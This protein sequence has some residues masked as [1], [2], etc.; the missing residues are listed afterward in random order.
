MSALQRQVAELWMGLT[1]QRNCGPGTLS[2]CV[3]D[4]G[5]SVAF[6]L[7]CIGCG[8]AVLLLAEEKADARQAARSG[9]ADFVVD[10]LSE[11]LRILKN[12]IRQHRPVAVALS[13]GVEAHLEGMVERGVQPQF[14]VAAH[15]GFH[16]W[17]ALV[18]RGAVR[19]DPQESAQYGLC[20]AALEGFCPEV[21]TAANVADRRALDER[22]LG[23]LTAVA[24][25]PGQRAATRWIQVAP[26]FFPRERDR[27]FWRHW[28]ER[29]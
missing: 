7:A 2:V 8:G 15:G 13:G 28:N 6:A 18:E 11:A 21:Q 19:V 4:E 22:L 25:G 24:P 9:A 27:V 29:A 10:T 26:R 23:E 12:E 14:A 16:P 3:Y 17:S 1:L 5:M 20:G